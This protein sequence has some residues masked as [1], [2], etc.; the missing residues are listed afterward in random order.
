LHKI[1]AEEAKVF[2]T[3]PNFYLFFYLII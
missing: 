3:K 2:N 1:T